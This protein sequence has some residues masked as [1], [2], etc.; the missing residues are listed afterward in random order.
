MDNLYLEISVIFEDCENKNKGRS[1]YFVLL[2]LF[3]FRAEICNR[4]S[5]NNIIFDYLYV[6][7]VKIIQLK[8]IYINKNQKNYIIKY[9]F[10]ILF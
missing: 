1:K 5:R 7:C 10:F 3:H 4:V 2:K 9:I 8:H 6:L